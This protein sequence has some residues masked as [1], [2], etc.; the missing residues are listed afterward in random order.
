[1]S[2]G[3]GANQSLLQSVSGVAV[4]SCEKLASCLHSSHPYMIINMKWG[5]VQSHMQ[6]TLEFFILYTH[7]CHDGTPFPS[8]GNGETIFHS[9]P[10]VKGH[11]KDR[12]TLGKQTSDTLR[13]P[14]T[15]SV[16]ICG[17]EHGLPSAL[18]EA[19]MQDLR[20]DAT[21]NS[22]VKSASI[23]HIHEADQQS[24][25]LFEV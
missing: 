1:M 2:R 24:M 20:A 3:T 8:F 10:L 7:T 18:Q 6:M 9:L 12:E 22:N 21:N 16:R 5:S 23:C 11:V 14:N 17:W 4:P 15:P 19:G 13:Q 25:A